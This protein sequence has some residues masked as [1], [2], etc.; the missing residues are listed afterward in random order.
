M[1][2]RRLRRG[3]AITLTCPDGTTTEVR[4]HSAGHQAVELHITAPQS[5]RITQEGTGADDGNPS[6]IHQSRR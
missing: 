6:A 4:V 3:E 5:I 2:K 1:L